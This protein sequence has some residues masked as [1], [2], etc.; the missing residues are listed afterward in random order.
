MVE[1]DLKG[2][3][4]SFSL[5]VNNIIESN[6]DSIDALVLAM[7]EGRVTSQALVEHA[8]AKAATYQSLNVFITL[9]AEGAMAAARNCD[10]L[11]ANNVSL[12]PLHGIPVVVKDNI[13]VAGLPN[14]AGTAGLR[15]FIPSEDASVVRRLKD[16]G[17]VVI[18]KTN[19]HEL[20]YGITSNNYVFGAVG[21]AMRSDYIAGGSSG[22]T[23]VAIAIG[24]APIGLGT[25][26]GGS[27]RIP[28]ALNGLVGFRPTTGRYPDD[29][30]TRI[31]FT[32][33]TVGPMAKTVKDII[34]LDRLLSA[35]PIENH[36]MHLSGLRLGVPRAHFYENLDPVIAEHTERLL[37][38][39]KV[40]GVTLVQADIEQLAEVNEKVGIPL[41]LY[42]TRILLEKYL[43]ANHLDIP[44]QMLV[45]AIVSPDVKAMVS[46][47][48]NGDITESVYRQAIE[49]YRPQLKKIYRDYFSEHSLDAV[50]YPTVPLVARP[51]AG[52]LET[53][54]LNGQQVPTFPTYIRNTDPGS[55]AGIP[56]LTLPLAL[57]AAGLPMGIEIDGPEGSDQ[58]LLALGSEIE[59]FIDQE[60]KRESNHMF[61]GE[62]YEQ[63]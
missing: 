55:N 61:Q 56:G 51:I 15:D 6:C 54:E 50:I 24:V 23:A 47:A 26:T 35:D 19:M 16:A 11:M 52:S 9:D 10:E 48:I 22:G 59:V 46:L 20:A 25:D 18:G 42:E 58:G 45:E 33:D 41:V 63:A 37:A 17:A 32:R 12:G 39:L 30:L 2:E 43:A 44:I 14:T 49:Q 4:M 5:A 60:D 31:S 62:H 3:S 38:C 7:S 1:P 36:S 13:H 21:N 34:L 27:S 53:V 40:A 29:G 8:L 57:S 28:A